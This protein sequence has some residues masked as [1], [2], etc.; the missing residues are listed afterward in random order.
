MWKYNEVI[1]TEKKPNTP[2]LK[3]YHMWKDIFLSFNNIDKYKVWLCGKF[4]DGNDTKDIDIVLTDSDDIN[5]TE[6][7]KILIDGI[8]LGLD[9]FNMFVDVQYQHVPPFYDGE[10]TFVTKKLI[11]TNKVIQDNKVLVDW[12]DGKQVS[13]NLWEY[14]RTLP[15]EK[16]LKRI[17]G[18]YVYKTPILL[19]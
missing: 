5:Y 4:L 17:R 16:Q 1:E 12:E 19:N 18:G 6:I 2:T 10:K 13:D 11:A 8:R 9:K 15:S 7:E 14:E 3:K